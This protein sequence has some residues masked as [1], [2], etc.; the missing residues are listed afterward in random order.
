[1]PDIV[2][3]NEKSSDQYNGPNSNWKKEKERVY[4]LPYF[5]GEPYFFWPINLYKLPGVFDIRTNPEL[6]LEML[7]CPKD[8]VELLP[9]FEV[10]Q[11]AISVRDFAVQ[12]KYAPPAAQLAIIS[13]CL[14]RQ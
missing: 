8:L 13:W 10:I 14:H 1:M 5:R 3:K 4:N 12:L 11:Y 7:K 6:C 2:P 9:N